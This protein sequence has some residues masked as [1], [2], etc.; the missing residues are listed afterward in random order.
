MDRVQ[1]PIVTAAW[2]PQAREALRYVAKWNETLTSEDVWDTLEE[3]GIG[4]PSDNRAMGP[5][6]RWGETEGLIGRTDH[7]FRADRP[8]R[9]RAPIQVYRSLLYRRST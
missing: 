5:V 3:M 1:S 2:L 7:F 6:M 9:H 8:S 4:T